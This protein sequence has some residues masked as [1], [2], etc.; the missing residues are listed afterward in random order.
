MFAIVE[1]EIVVVDGRRLRELALFVPAL[2]ILASIFLAHPDPEARC[3]SRA[4][5]VESAAP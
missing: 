1:D 5:R 4:R 2:A 3:S